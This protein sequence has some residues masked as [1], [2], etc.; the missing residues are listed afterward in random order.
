MEKGRNLAAE[1]WRELPP[2]GGNP[3]SASALHKRLSSPRPSR[4]TL[5]QALSSLVL[6]GYAEAIQAGR[7]TYYRRTA[8]RLTPPGELPDTTGRI[9]EVCPVETQDPLFQKL[10]PLRRNQPVHLAMNVKRKAI[11]KG[12]DTTARSLV[13]MQTGVTLGL[14]PELILISIVGSGSVLIDPFD[15]SAVSKLVLSGMPASLARI[16]MTQLHRVLRSS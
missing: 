12:Q 7:F 9:N 2:W 6:L 1:V 16:L 4:D 3:L 14:R 8:N 5:T 11:R 13:L 10:L 15:A